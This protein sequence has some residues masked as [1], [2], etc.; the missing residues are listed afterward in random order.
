MS[1]TTG[2]AVRGIEGKARLG[3]E[4]LDLG[5]HVGEI[6]GIDAADAHEL[7]AHRGLPAAAGSR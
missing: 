1:G 7:L 3:I 2:S 4:R 5:H 6:L